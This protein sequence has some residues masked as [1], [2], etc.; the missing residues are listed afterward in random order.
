ML[1]DSSTVLFVFLVHM[2]LTLTVKLKY[3]GLVSIRGL[4]T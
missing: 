1:V 4:G 3:L 2:I